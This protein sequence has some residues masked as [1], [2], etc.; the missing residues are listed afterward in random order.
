[1]KVKH[2]KELIMLTIAIPLFIVFFM[3][4]FIIFTLI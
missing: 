4:I 3:L 2:E 1:M